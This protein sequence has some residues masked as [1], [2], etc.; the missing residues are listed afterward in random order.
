[1]LQ[2]A[3]ARA[4]KLHGY[5]HHQDYLETA[6]APFRT[7]VVLGEDE[8]GAA[9]VCSLMVMDGLTYLDIDPAADLDRR[10][11]VAQMVFGLSPGQMALGPHR[12][13]RES[14]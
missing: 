5:F 13:G 10:L 3:I 6:G 4:G 11:A 8:T 12:L 9:I 2:S 14:D 7:P 1:M